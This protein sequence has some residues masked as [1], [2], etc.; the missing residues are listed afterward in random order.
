MSQQTV[1]SELYA[2]EMTYQYENRQSILRGMVNTKT[3]SGGL[4]HHFIVDSK[5]PAAKTRGANGDIPVA[6]VSQYDVTVTLAEYHALIQMNSFNIFT[7]SVDQRLS[8]QRR[9]VASINQITD[10]LIVTEMAGTTYTTGAA[11]AMSLNLA[12]KG[13]EVLYSNEVEND[14][15]LYGLLSPRAWAQLMKVKEF[16]SSDYVP[17]QPF[18]KGYQMREFLGVKWCMW[19]RLP[20]KNTAACKCFVFHQDA[21]GHAITQGEMSTVIGYEEKQDRSFCRSTSYQG[22]K[23]ILPPGVCIITHDD[24]AAI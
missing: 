8:M 10:Q 19:S 5:A 6:D 7:S 24:T 1:T 16:A 21:V 15:K 20:G 23:L 9:T 2:E 18:M 14:G 3:I 13:V 4:K 17:D 12:L 22:S 11:A